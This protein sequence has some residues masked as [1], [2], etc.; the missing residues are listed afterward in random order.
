MVN[1]TSG[2]NPV[3]AHMFID[4][5]LDVDNALE[6]YSYVGYMQPLNRGHA[7]PG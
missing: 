1:L 7:Q 6:N 3:L 5:M 2:Q 4:Y